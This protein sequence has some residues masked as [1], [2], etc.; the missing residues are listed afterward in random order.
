MS[1][2]TQIQQRYD[3]LTQELASPALDGSKRHIYQ[4]E[5]SYLSTLL[6]KHAEIS[7]L[8]KQLEETTSQA[9]SNADPE[10]AELYTIEI[11]DLQQALTLQQQ[12]LESL[13]YP[14]NPLDERSVFVEIRAGNGRPRSS[15][16]CR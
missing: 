6:S 8:E 11:Q 4:K 13:M 2:W 12:Q 7:S 16:I 9:A 15:F 14:P 10:L 5:H 3:E 1:V